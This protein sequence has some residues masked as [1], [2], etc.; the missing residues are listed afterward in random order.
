[1]LKSVDK[2]TKTAVFEDTSS[3]ETSEVPYDFLHIV[4]P[5]TPHEFIANSPLAGGGGFV[6]AD[7]YTMQ[8]PKYENV[9]SCGDTAALPASKTAASAFSQIPVLVHNLN[10]LSQG[11]EPT[12]KYNGYGSCPLFTGDKK[13]MLAEFAYGG[14]AKETFHSSQDKPSKLFYYLKKEVFPKVYFGLVPQGVWYGNKTVF[15]PKF[16]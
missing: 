5:Q 16:F 4:P 10:Q 1:M 11:E 8:H 12:A 9:F 2:D 15:K 6:A 3:G 13:L 14:E 7:Q